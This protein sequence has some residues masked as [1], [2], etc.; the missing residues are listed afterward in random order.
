MPVKPVPEGYL[1]TPYLI[2]RGAPQAIEF[3]KKA[4][5]AT[6]SE[7]HADPSGKVAHAEIRIGKAPIML[8][9]EHP[10]MGFKGPESYGGSPVTIVIYTKD[11]DALFQ[12]AVA[13]GATVLRAVADQFYGD[14]NGTLKDPFGHVWT[15]MTHVEDVSPKEVQKRMAAALKKK[16]QG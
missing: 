14:R 13:A 2:L 8:A 6:V 16:A 10:E 7:Q 4:F 1:A 3:Y 12:R 9:D 5:G 11:V 15:L